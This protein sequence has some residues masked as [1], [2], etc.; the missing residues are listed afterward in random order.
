ME[1]NGLV[2]TGSITGDT[3]TVTSITHGRLEIGTK[4]SGNGIPDGTKITAFGSG[5]GGVG[6]Y[7]IN[8]S[9]N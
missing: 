7:K 8:T 3:L 9:V 1:K 2:M 5:H 4:L 6:T